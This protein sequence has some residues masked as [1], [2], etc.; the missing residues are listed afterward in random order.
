[1]LLDTQHRKVKLFQSIPHSLQYTV[2][3]SQLHDWKRARGGVCATVPARAQ[4]GRAIFVRSQTL[5]GPNVTVISGSKHMLKQS[6]S[7]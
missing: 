2:M 6:Q 3:T 1:M 5:N 7:T 4:E